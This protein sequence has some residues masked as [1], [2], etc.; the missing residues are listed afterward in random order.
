ML[1]CLQVQQNKQQI[2]IIKNNKIKNYIIM[3]MYYVAVWYDGNYMQPHY[4]NLSASEKANE[5]TFAEKLNLKGPSAVII[6]WSLRE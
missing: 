2:I 6:A 3:R 1:Q 4:V 5:R